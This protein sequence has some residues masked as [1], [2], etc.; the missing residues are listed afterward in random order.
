MWLS[1]FY[2]VAIAIILAYLVVTIMR[3]KDVPPSISETYYMWKGVGKE[4]V[5]T[6]VMWIVA[7]SITIYW[8][9]VAK[10]YKC[11]FLTFL[12]VAGMCFVGGACMFKQTLTEEVHYTSAGIWAG[13]ATL[14]FLV[15]Q[16]FLPMILG[17]SV[18][19]IGWVLNRCRNLTFWSELACVAMMIIGI[20]ML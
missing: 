9:S 4:W 17:L 16:M 1:V 5:F 11:Q 12:S 13:G 3:F 15:N 8:V 7:I 10:D 6:F 2:Y 18:G 19:F 20:F 14:F